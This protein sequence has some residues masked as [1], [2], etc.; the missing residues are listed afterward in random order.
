MLIDKLNLLDNCYALLVFESRTAKGLSREVVAGLAGLSSQARLYELER[1]QWLPPDAEVVDNIS[2]AMGFYKEQE[3][4]IF[5]RAYGC[6]DAQS[7]GLRATCKHCAY[8]RV[9]NALQQRRS[10]TL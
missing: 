7:K 1:G 3:L 6:T 5:R 2:K 10:A 4:E 9:I 8:P